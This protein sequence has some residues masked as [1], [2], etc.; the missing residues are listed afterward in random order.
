MTDNYL[1]MPMMWE[2]SSPPAHATVTG[3]TVSTYSGIWQPSKS[4]F[5]TNYPTNTWNDNPAGSGKKI[6]VRPNAYEAGRG[7]IFIINYDLSNS[8]NVDISTVV[9]VGANYE[10]RHALNYF[11]A[12][13]VSGTYAGGTVSVPM[14]TLTMATPVGLPTPTAQYPRV[15]AFVIRTV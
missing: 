3:N 5:T 4:F 10:I 2:T 12:P 13:A 9:G 7:H 11:A 6:V 1:D 15:A 8:V 14:N